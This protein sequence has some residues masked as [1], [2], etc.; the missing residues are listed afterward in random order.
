MAKPTQRQ[1]DLVQSDAIDLYEHLEQKMF[2]LFAKYL[3]RNGVPKDDASTTDVLKWQISRLSELHMLN[4]EA[5]TE[6]SKTTGIAERKLRHLFNDL[7]Y[8][9]AQGEYKRVSDATGSG[10]EPANIDQLMGGYLKQTFLELDNTVNQTLLTTNYG[11]N[12]VTNTYQQI[13]KESVADAITGV[14]TPQQAIWDTVLKWQQKGLDTGLIDKGGHHW[15]IA[16]YARLVVGT[17]TNRAFQ[18]VRDKAAEDNGIDIFLMSSHA[19]SREACATI[20][21]NLVTTRPEDFET[22]THEHVYALDNWGYGEPGGTFGINC[23]HT[24]WAYVPGVNTNGLTQYDPQEA[25]ANGETQARQRALERQIRKYKQNAELAS[26]MGDEQGKKH[27]QLLVRRN[28]A[29]VRKLV[30]DN[31]FLRRDY[32]REKAEPGYNKSTDSNRLSASARHVRAQIASGAWGKLINPEKQAP[33]MESTHLPGK[34]Y[35]FDSENPQQLLDEYSGTG[36]L[37]V[38]KDGKLGNVETVQTNHVLGIDAESGE[39]VQWMKIHHSKARTHIVP[40]KINRGG[41]SNGSK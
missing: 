27:Y 21:G 18:A 34:S 37:N 3:T 5:V 22:D 15:G 14:R 33:H 24:K 35:L 10:V 7:G 30:K 23:R 28:Q 20:Q 16:S 6:V 32:S 2:R 8:K 41:D 13:V 17:T 29:A 19:A 25:V 12:A 36:Q 31:D 40:I 4:R 39:E 11:E 1:L 38:Q 9:Y 26:D